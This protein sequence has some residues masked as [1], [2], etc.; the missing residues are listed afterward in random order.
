[1]F[2]RYLRASAAASHFCTICRA[3][4]GGGPRPLQPRGGSRLLPGAALAGG[5]YVG[6]GCRAGWR[7]APPGCRV[8][9][10][11]GCRRKRSAASSSGSGAA[12]PAAGPCRE[13][14]MLTLALGKTQKHRGVMLRPPE[15][16][17][18]GLEQDCSQS[19]LHLL[20]VDQLGC[21]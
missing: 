9:A 8:T 18:S 1:M 16:Q 19:P 6:A 11:D 13:T 21:F 15:R 5:S 2:A 17:K 4:M 10:G 20:V 3:L 12:S 7:A 14:H